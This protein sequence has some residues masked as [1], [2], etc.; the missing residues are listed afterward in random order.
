MGEH[1][2]FEVVQ[3][4]IQAGADKDL[5]QEQGATPLFIATEKGHAEVVNELISAGADLDKQKAGGWSPM[6][7]AAYHD[8]TAIALALLRSARCN[9]NLQTDMG[10]TV[11]Y[12][13]AQAGNA[14]T[15]N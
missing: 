9:P 2:H 12:L 7:N 5:A 3:A 11:V 1:G 13:A 4:L 15:L 14:D 10:C 6:H 8:R